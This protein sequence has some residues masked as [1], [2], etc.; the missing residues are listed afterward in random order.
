MILYSH[1]QFYQNNSGL[2]N[3]LNYTRQLEAKQSSSLSKVMPVIKY[4]KVSELRWESY[5]RTG[6]GV[7]ESYFCFYPNPAYLWFRI[8][9]QI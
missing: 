6:C 8:N 9:A 1:N 3:N 5:L 2:L 4:W 7:P